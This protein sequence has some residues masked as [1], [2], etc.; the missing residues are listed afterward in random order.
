[1]SGVYERP[2]EGEDRALVKYR[3]RFE[4][5]YVWSNPSV[6]DQLGWYL[7]VSANRM[8]AKYLIWR[9]IPCQVDLKDASEDELWDSKTNRKL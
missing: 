5:L 9:R 2:R 3:S 4:S 8:P 7:A 1:V 6:R